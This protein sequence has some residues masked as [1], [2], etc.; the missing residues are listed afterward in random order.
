[1]KILW[2]CPFKRLF[3]ASLCS[4]VVARPCASLHLWTLATLFPNW[5]EQIQFIMTPLHYKS[6]FSFRILLEWKIWER[7]LLFLVKIIKASFTL[8]VQHIGLFYTQTVIIV[9]HNY[10]NLLLYS[11]WEQRVCCWVPLQ[12]KKDG[13]TYRKGRR[14]EEW[15]NGGWK[16]RKWEIRQL[17]IQV[18]PHPP[19][20]HKRV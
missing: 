4:S 12:K 15:G 3:A 16:Q 13:V 11:Y 2:Q 17:Q 6:F 20:K 10:I 8:H 18:N 5:K 19:S 14:G 9:R 1:M 7:I